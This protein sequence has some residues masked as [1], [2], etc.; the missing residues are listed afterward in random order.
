MPR[1][2]GKHQVLMDAPISN[3]YFL[4]VR[5]TLLFTGVDFL[6]SLALWRS[7]PFRAR[8]VRALYQGGDFPLILRNRRTHTGDGRCIVW[9]HGRWERA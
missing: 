9:G 1:G 7:S 5:E 3:K 4:P 6:S 8:I 2:E